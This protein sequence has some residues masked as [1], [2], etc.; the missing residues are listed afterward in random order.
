M[1]SNG[2]VIMPFSIIKMPVRRI[3][4]TAILLSMLSGTTLLTN[5]A[6][7]GEKEAKPKKTMTLQE[8]KQQYVRPKEI[9]YLKDNP[10]SKE[11]YELGWY[12]FFDNR[13]SG[14]KQHNCSTCHAQSAAWGDVAE[15]SKAHG[16][17]LT[18][19]HSPMMLNL[20]WDE[21]SSWDGRTTT[22]ETQAIGPIKNP[23]VMNLPI[24]ELVKRLEIVPEYKAMFA[25]AF[26]EDPLI[27]EKNIGKAIAMFER[28]LVSGVAPF[29]KWI[30]GD[31]KAINESAKRGFVLFNTK[32]N[33]AVCHSGWR[34]TDAGF[35]DIGLPNTN[36]DL[37]R[38]K[39]LPKI[40]T[41]KY[42][43]KTPGLRNVATS[44]PYMHNGSVKTLE[45]VMTHYNGAFVKRPS[46]SEE[47]KLLH[48]SEKEKKDI[49]AFLHTLTGADTPIPA[50]KIP[51][52]PK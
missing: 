38:G 36:N 26:P 22:L 40:E 25:K 49:V 33:C 9:P 2:E 10:Y 44:A 19:R 51:A 35:H 5:I 41:M 23:G 8:M 17:K 48:L 50:P 42:A 28:N 21:L 46:L 12:L 39:Y 7:A 15:R 4:N 6:Y 30:S 18:P 47:V 20:A 27:N 43:F 1:T 24:P 29:D 37:G 14:A 52:D 13:L 31:E 3:F 16:G 32:G 45:D 34:F 11:K